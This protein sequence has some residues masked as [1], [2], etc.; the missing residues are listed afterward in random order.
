VILV[1]TER[2][3]KEQLPFALQSIQ[4]KAGY[5]KGD[6][7]PNFRYASLLEV[8]RK[9]RFNILNEYL[10]KLKQEI[11]N[12]MFI[13]LDVL[14]DCVE[15][16]NRPDKSLELIDSLNIAVNEY[17]VVFVCVIHQNPQSEK[18]RGHL[19]TELLNK[20]STTISTAFEKDSNN[21]DLDLLKIK[22]Q[23][24]RSTARHTPFYAKYSEE[25]RGLVLADIDDIQSVTNSKKQ[26]ADAAIVIEHLEMYL[27]DG[28]KMMRRTLLDKLI[29]ELGVSEKTL[30]DRLK[31]I[32]TGQLTLEN[33]NGLECYLEKDKSTR[34]IKYHLVPKNPVANKKEDD[35]GDEPMQ[36]TL[37]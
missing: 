3:H 22:F 1:D 13:V 32:C 9:D 24:C 33:E 2:N 17:D 11:K 31:E 35:S 6:H 27:G 36:Q 4:L 30:E 37:L 29:S 14:T 25:H 34:E 5:N 15:D 10:D 16:F 28:T 19:G 21:Q 26:K 23:K 18:M 20:S 12:P 7:P 8:P